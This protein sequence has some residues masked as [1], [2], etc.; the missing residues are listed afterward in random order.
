MNHAQVSASLSYGSHRA[1]TEGT[2]MLGEQI[3]LLGSLATKQVVQ[4]GEGEGKTKEPVKPG[5]RV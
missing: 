5:G 1:A 2:I 4:V 3:A